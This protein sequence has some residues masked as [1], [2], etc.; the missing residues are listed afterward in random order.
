MRPVTIIEPETRIVLL[1]NGRG[2]CDKDLPCS[3]ERIYLQ[4]RP[5]ITVYMPENVGPRGGD[6]G[7]GRRAETLDDATTVPLYHGFMIAPKTTKKTRVQ[8]F[9]S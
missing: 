1:S 9:T 4:V 6:G 8:D 5:L 3:F 2:Q 7:A